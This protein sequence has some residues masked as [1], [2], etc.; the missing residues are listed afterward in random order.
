MA[1]SYSPVEAGLGAEQHFLSL[2][3]ILMSQERLP[4]RA[5]I[6]LPRLASV[7]SKATAAST[8]PHNTLPEVRKQPSWR[9]R[10]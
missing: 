3:D 7:L 2:A 6:A 1:E 5:E 8:A 10:K 4:C 9:F